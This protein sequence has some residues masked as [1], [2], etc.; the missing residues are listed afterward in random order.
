MQ[1]L[2]EWIAIKQEEL[3]EKSKVRTLTQTLFFLL[4]FIIGNVYR[5]WILLKPMSK[6]SRIKKYKEKLHKIFADYTDR[7][8][9][10]TIAYSL[11]VIAIVIG[12]AVAVILFTFD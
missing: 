7:E 11:R 8:L 10:E 3:T 6:A 9:L 4:M 5:D 2:S 12:V 1:I